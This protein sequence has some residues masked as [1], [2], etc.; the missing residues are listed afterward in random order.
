MHY[1]LCS[2]YFVEKLYQKAKENME[3]NEDW[4]TEPTQEKLIIKLPILNTMIIAQ[5]VFPKTLESLLVHISSC[6]FR[7]IP[8][9]NQILSSSAFRLL[10]TIIQV[11]PT[12]HRECFKRLHLLQHLSG[13]ILACLQGLGTTPEDLDKREGLYEALS[14]CYLGDYLDDYIVNSHQFVQQIFDPRAVEGLTD[15]VALLKI[16]KDVTG[17]LKG[18]NITE[19]VIAFT[20]IW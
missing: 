7:S 5:E 14:K 2:L 20:R 4:E 3:Q 17:V 11:K 19:V 1:H 6:A 16:L 10:N 8:A 15:E 12:M 13:Q 18:I 9:K